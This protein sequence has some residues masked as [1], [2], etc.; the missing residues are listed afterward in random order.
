MEVW[1][2][3]VLLGLSSIAFLWRVYKMRWFSW[4]LINPSIRQRGSSLQTT[5]S[6]DDLN[7]QHLHLTIRDILDNNIG[8]RFPYSRRFS[9]FVHQNRKG[10]VH[11]Q[12]TFC[13]I[14][15]SLQL[16]VGGNAK[17][18]LDLLWNTHILTG[19]NPANGYTPI[20]LWIINKTKRFKFTN[21][22]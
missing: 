2:G 3:A 17:R 18:S 16:C 21:H 5:F 12:G 14:W 1:V 10:L 6:G 4:H 7:C 22:I 19:S 13:R 9:K 8:K 15:E 11:F 20:L